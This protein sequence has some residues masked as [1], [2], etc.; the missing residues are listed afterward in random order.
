[1][2]SA[3]LVLAILSALFGFVA[4]YFWWKASRVD[5]VSKWDSAKVQ[6]GQASTQSLR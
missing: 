1:M 5:I 2:K 3:A 6:A 4:A